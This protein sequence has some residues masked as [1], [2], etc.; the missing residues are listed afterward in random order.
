M[1]PDCYRCQYGDQAHPC[2]TSDGNLDFEKIARAIVESRQAF[3]TDTI[4]EAIVA[5]TRWASDCAFEIEENH[6]DELFAL[7]LVAMDLCRDLEDAAFIAAGL[8]ENMLVKHGPELIDAIEAMAAASAKFRYILS[9]AWSQ[10]GSVDPDVWERVGRAVAQGA[11]MSDDA[12]GPWDGRA[13]TVLDDDAAL[14][15]LRESVTGAALEIGLIG[16]AEPDST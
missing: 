7:T 2:R 3:L 11:R 8:V 6:P 9:G 1:L 16:Q 10:N 14:G 15:L 5:R 13:V 4:D 12:R